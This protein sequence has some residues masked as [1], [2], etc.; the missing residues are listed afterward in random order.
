[1]LVLRPIGRDVRFGFG[2]GFAPEELDL[3]LGGAAESLR[4]NV[5]RLRKPLLDVLE[6]SMLVARGP[7]PAEHVGH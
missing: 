7:A 2:F 3:E 5:T 4:I 6:E 1:L